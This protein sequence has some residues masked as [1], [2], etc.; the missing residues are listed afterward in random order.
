MPKYD[1]LRKTKRDNM[2]RRFASRHPKL[3]QQELAD[4]YGI[5]RSNISR[6][7]RSGN[8]HSP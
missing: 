5:A 3:S 7:L 8:H 2:I 4:R 6:I 1:S